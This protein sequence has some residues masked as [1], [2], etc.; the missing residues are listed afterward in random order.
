[1]NKFW[2]KFY[3]G[4]AE[5]WISD[6]LLPASAFLGIGLLSWIWRNGITLFI[7]KLQAIDTTLGVV[8]IISMF[9]GIA[10][11]GWLV[12]QI[13]QIFLKL[14]EGYWPQSL[15]RVSRYLIRKVAKKTQ[16]SKDRLQIL[17]QKFDNLSSD[18]LAE[19]NKLD[20]ELAITPK[21]E[22]N[23]MPSQLGNILKSAEEYPRIRYGLEASIVWPRLWLLL[24]S[25]TQKEI[26]SA[27]SAVNEEVRLIIWG[28]LMLIWTIWAWWAVLISTVIV[29]V[30]YLSLV[31]SA[32]RLGDLIRSVFD[33]NRFKLYEALHWDFPNDL[34]KEKSSGAAITQFLYRGKI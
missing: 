10:V 4:L 25:D 9:F 27:R 17:A 16:A 29:I 7:Q 11:L 8:I 18:E 21:L 31:G 26:I 20:N 32:K 30:S 6:L 19:Y 5:K 22:A 12:Q 33:L 15:A 3:E 1:M 28:I 34:S 24:T 23:L 13:T 14:C 2:E